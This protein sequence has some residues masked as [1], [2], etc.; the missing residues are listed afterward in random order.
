MNYSGCQHPPPRPE[1]PPLQVKDLVVAHEGA[2]LP[3]LHGIS[4]T[5]KKKE[6]VALIGPNGAGKST[7]LKA[8]VHLLK[9]RAG[10]IELFGHSP[11]TCHH[12]VAY[13][14]QRG[15]LDW[16]FPIHLRRMVLSGRYVQRGWF[17]RP[18][19]S[20]RKT[21]DRILSLLRLEDLADRQIGELS[22]GQQ[23]R[24][25]LARALVQ[26][27]E[28][29]LLDEPFNAVDDETRKLLIEVLETLRQEDKTVIIATHEPELEGLPF[30]RIFPFLEGRLVDKPATPP[31]P[32]CPHE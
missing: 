10:Q 32:A 14:P 13:L 21:V 28:M 20:D 24:A 3:A 31:K 17:K 29:L 8:V 5:V 6:R 2:H 9:P 26:E 18:S 19:E 30:D 7:F 25:M 4:L 15:E 12:R 1:A 11:G 22:G 23:Q 27:A 16:D